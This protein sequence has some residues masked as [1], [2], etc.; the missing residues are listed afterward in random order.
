MELAR[1]EPGEFV[2]GSP[3]DESGRNWNEKQHRVRITRA[4]YLG[5]TEVTQ[6]QWRAVMGND[7]SR[8][9]GDDLPIEQLR[10]GDASEFCLKLSQR[11][12]KT[13]RLPTEA[14]W[15][16]ACRAGSTG[17]YAG[18]GRAEDMAW[19]TP[20]SDGKT[21]P[22]ARKKPNAWGLYDM[23]GN[24]WEWCLDCFADEYPEG[25]MTDPT[26][27]ALGDYRVIRGGSWNTP[28]GRSAWRWKMW[29]GYA[30]ADIGFR[31]VMESP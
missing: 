27:P 10:W 1:I 21:H 4:F 18:T 24:V 25:S 31:C 26:G 16:Y 2:M 20:D 22:V 29:P 13:F 23:H 3:D 11:T 15:E 28:S 9:K 14:E 12:G 8:F 17:A 19:F 6:A 5:M 30:W 7:A